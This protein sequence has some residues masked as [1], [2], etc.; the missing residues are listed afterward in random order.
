MPP[1]LPFPD[2]SGDALI[3]MWPEV[4]EEISLLNFVYELK[5]LRTI[6]ETIRSLRR[7]WEFFV[8]KKKNNALIS[9]LSDVYLQ[10]EFG[11]QPLIRD[12]RAGISAAQNL[13]TKFLKYFGNQNK[14][15]RRHFTRRYVPSSVPWSTAR[16]FATPHGSPTTHRG[17]HLCGVPEVTY[18][19]TMVYSYSL[20]GLG[21]LDGHALRDVLQTMFALDLFGVNLNPKHIWEAIPFSFL[22]DYFVKV[23]DW[24][25]QFKNRSLDP[26]VVVWEWIESIRYTVSR[27][28]WV[29]PWN[30]GPNTWCFTGRMR[31]ETYIRRLSAP[32]TY[33]SLQA[34]GLSGRQIINMAALG[35]ARSGARR[36]ASTHR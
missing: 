18:T 8:A 14:I 6:P 35:G 26:M 4:E 21:P 25:D 3:A 5:D 30:Y 19:A 2:L 28:H 12:V 9:D 29:L 24:L 32:D 36:G 22:V 27:D 20:P 13:E 1:D 11:V 17:K 15:L 16:E 31:R 7:I 33:S 10:N 34:S 23:G